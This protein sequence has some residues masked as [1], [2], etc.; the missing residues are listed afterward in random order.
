[1][2]FIKQDNAD[3][4]FDLLRETEVKCT[5]SGRTFKFDIPHGT[6]ISY[7]RC[8]CHQKAV[9]AWCFYV[10][11]PNDIGSCDHFNEVVRWIKKHKTIKML[12]D[13]ELICEI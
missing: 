2:R 5:S 8:G 4:F 9:G 10:I 7:S 11:S 6:K 13:G 3:K 1:M 12:D